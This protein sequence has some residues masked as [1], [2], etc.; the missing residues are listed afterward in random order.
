MLWRLIFY[1]FRAPVGTSES[2]IKAHDDD[3]CPDDAFG[4]RKEF[5]FLFYEFVSYFFDFSVGQIATLY[6]RKRGEPV[7]SLEFVPR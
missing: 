5:A 4:S 2:I 1:F 7:D 6:A 3:E